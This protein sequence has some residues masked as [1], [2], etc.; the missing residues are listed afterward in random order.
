MKPNLLMMCLACVSDMVRLGDLS[1]TNVTCKPDE[2]RG[3]RKFELKRPIS[4]LERSSFIYDFEKG[5][6]VVAAWK[7]SAIYLCHERPEK[8]SI[9][10]QEVGRL[11]HEGNSACWSGTFVA[12]VMT[13]Q[14]ITVRL[15]KPT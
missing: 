9:T 4:Y 1:I 13:A 14:N 11:A 3:A 5:C 7:A 12:L 2:Y 15:Q 6:S 10:S 8:I